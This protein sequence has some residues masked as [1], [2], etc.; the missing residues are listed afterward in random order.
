MY[1]SNK[2]QHVQ[3]RLRKNN[4]EMV[5]WIPKEC[6]IEGK[7]VDLDDPEQGEAKGW[8]VL[9]VGSQSVDSKWIRERSR[10]AKNWRG[11]TD[12]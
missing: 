12:V 3:C 6:A 10:D 9:E 1:M 5:A 8:I 11:V 4:T 2:D 7:T